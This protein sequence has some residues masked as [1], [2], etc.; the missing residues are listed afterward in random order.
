MKKKQR[1]GK[2][3]WESISNSLQKNTYWEKK[4]KIRLTNAK[5][6]FKMK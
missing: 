6:K 3:K 1:R 2:A 4:V 5:G